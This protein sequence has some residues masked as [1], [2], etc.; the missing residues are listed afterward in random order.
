MEEP[1]VCLDASPSVYKNA[2]FLTSGACR[3]AP[4]QGA[5]QRAKSPRAFLRRLQIFYDVDHILGVV[6]R[7]NEFQ[8]LD[9]IANAML[10]LLP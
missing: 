9:P 8:T 2:R 3:R 6:D 5:V 4:P 7:I 10:S 1:L